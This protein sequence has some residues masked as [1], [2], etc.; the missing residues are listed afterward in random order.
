[1]PIE[2]HL[3]RASEF[4][5]L[6]ADE[7]IDFE[8]SK[9]VLQDLAVACRKRGIGRAM[10]DIRNVPVPDKPRFTPAQLA[11][12]AGAF[13]EA[14]FTRQQRL[15]ILYKHDAYGGVRN[16]TFFSKLR[17]L[18]VQAFHEFEAAF[19]WLAE[20]SS[21]ELGQGAEVPILKPDAQT[22]SEDL[23]GGIKR[24]SALRPVRRPKGHI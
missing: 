21:A 14:G 6:D 3:I 20:E 2:L 18:Q 9:R 5:R 22:R 24:A 17:G 4:I 16:F 12:L 10:V 23:V 15:A 1:M 19:Y 11:A 13:R 7:H 8:A